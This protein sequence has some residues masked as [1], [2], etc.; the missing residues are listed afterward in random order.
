LG[1]WAL[2]KIAQAK[3][4]K[5]NDFDTHELWW[6]HEGNGVN[7]NAVIPAQFDPAA[8]GVAWNDTVVTLTK[9]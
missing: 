3:K 2:G 7:P 6:E 8:G 5:S 4:Y 9:V 1:H